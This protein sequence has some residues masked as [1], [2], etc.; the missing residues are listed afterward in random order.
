MEEG[1]ILSW[2]VESLISFIRL[3]PGAKK[4]LV[5]FSNQNNSDF[6]EIDKTLKFQLFNLSNTAKEKV[7]N[8]NNSDDKNPESY[9]TSMA[10]LLV[11]HFASCLSSS[12]WIMSTGTRATQS[13]SHV[14][15]SLHFH[16]TY[17]TA[18]FKGKRF[19]FS[20]ISLFP[21]RNLMEHIYI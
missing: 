17:F 1:T 12:K 10:C 2:L 14:W 9:F 16:D 6:T 4:L 8:E 21:E 18:F 19:G 7:I 20:K 15:R 3:I 13:M 11:C 5:E